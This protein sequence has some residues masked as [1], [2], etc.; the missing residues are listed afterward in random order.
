MHPAVTYQ[1][2]PTNYRSQ[3]ALLRQGDTLALASGTYSFLN[4]TGLN[5]APSAWIRDS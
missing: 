2:N 4:V 5:G 3:L 1:A